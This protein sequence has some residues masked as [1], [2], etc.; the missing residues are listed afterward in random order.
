MIRERESRSH[1]AQEVVA[2]VDPAQPVF[3]LKTL[4]EVLAASFTQPRFVAALLSVFA[5]LALVL[6]AL[7]TH[8]VMALSLAQRRREI[9]IRIAL[10][11]AAREVAGLVLGK[12]LRLALLGLLLGFPAGFAITCAL[13]SIVEGVQPVDVEIYRGIAALL[14]VRAARVPPSIALQ[15]E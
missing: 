5:A 12:G 9:G 11:A 13:A 15:A 2:E 3:H 1:L 14:G 10:G 7:G 6:A 8:A 4:E